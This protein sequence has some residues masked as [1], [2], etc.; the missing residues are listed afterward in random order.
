MTSL[1]NEIIN[2]EYNKDEQLILN[3]TYEAETGRLILSDNYDNHYLCDLFGRIKTKFLP[4]ITGQASYLERKNFNSA[5]NFQSKKNKNENLQTE[6]NTDR[7]LTSKP[8][9]SI[10]KEVINY[11]PII[12]KLEG[13]SKFPRPLSPPFTNMPDYKLKDQIK[14]ELIQH[15]EKFFSENYTKELFKKNYTS[16]GLSYLTLDLNEFDCVKVDNEKILS[17]INQTLKSIKENYNYKISV[18]YK[19]PIVKALS[20]FSKFLL[21]NKDTTIINNRKLTEPN[22]KIKKRYTY[23][24]SAISRHGLDKKNKAKNKY[25]YRN[26]LTLNN[27]MYNLKGQIKFRNLTL[28]SNK[29]SNLNNYNYYWNSLFKKKDFNI[30]KKIKM[31]FGSFLYEEEK[32]KK[33]NKNMTLTQ[34]SNKKKVLTETTKENEEYNKGRNRNNLSFISYKDENINDNKKQVKGINLMKNRYNKEKDLLKGFQIEERKGFMY[35]FKNIKPK[36]KTNG[37]LYEEDMKLLRRTN[38]IAFKIQEKREAFN[39]KQLI[40]KINTQRIIADNIMKGKKLII[41]KEDNDD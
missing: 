34:E 24:H 26:K 27:K 7:P 37:E 38:P 9:F 11:H 17:L 20:Q 28:E 41:K 14:A 3:L 6:E 40:K 33:I 10:K 1:D 39:L 21:A 8:L 12:R 31:D 29:D 35:L 4:N 2:D 5:R 25:Y 18:Y 13:Y 23:I 16:K 22:P 19:L 32:R 30:G 36:L 15:L